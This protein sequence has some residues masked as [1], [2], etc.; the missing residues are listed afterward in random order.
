[1]PYEAIF[2]RDQ[3]SR[4]P[5]GKVMIPMYEP[6]E[7][8]ECKKCGSLIAELRELIKIVNHLSEKTEDEILKLIRLIDRNKTRTFKFFDV[9]WGDFFIP[10][11]AFAVTL[12]IIWVAFVFELKVLFTQDFIGIP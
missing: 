8:S 10:F 6:L 7:V 11:V 9:F 12:A 4:E 2:D 1:M 3:P 5:K